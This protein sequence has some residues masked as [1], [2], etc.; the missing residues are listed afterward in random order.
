[1]IPGGD[2]CYHVYNTEIMTQARGAEHM[3]KR[4]L[5]VATLEPRL[6]L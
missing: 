2:V 3:A 6:T 4:R 1:M 5:D